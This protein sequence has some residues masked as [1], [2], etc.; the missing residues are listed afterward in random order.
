[1]KHEDLPQRWKDK[2]KKWLAARGAHG[3]EKLSAGD[4]S[5]DATVKITFEDGSHAQFNYPL[6]IEAPEWNEVG[7]FTEH[8]GYHIFRAGSIYALEEA[9]R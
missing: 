8:C 9:K 2:I 3:Q 7:V 5:L 6:V 1:M 4:F